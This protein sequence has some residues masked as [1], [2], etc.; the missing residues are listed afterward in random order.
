MDCIHLPHWAGA[1]GFFAPGSRLP[2]GASI[3]DTELAILERAVPGRVSRPARLDPGLLCGLS[4][5]FLLVHGTGVRRFDTAG[6]LG[7]MIERRADAL[8]AVHPRPGADRPLL[9]SPDGRIASFGSDQDSNLRDSGVWL[10]GRRAAVAGGRDLSSPRAFLSAAMESGAALY[11]E[12]LASYC[13]VVCSPEDFLALCGDVLG[14]RIPEAA[15]ACAAT[16][17]VDP[18]ASVGEGAGL[19]GLV[20]IDCGARIGRGCRV[21]DS[22]VLGEACVGDGSVLRNVLVMPRGR[23]AP[24]S[25]LSD[26]YIKIIGG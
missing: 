1:P 7:E 17:I 9:C 10:V 13:R 20:W 2:G 16:Q 15:G 24:S 18:G 14:G 6:L 3:G 12:C 4:D 5:P 25:D 19:E 8:V 26:K 22:V 11:S 23:V 21:I